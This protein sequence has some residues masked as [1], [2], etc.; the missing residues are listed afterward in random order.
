M[1]HLET[2][3]FRVTFW[4]VRGSIPCPGQKTLRYGGNTSCIEMLVGQ[5]RLIFDGGT[6]LR[7]LG[8]FL[9][10]TH[11]QQKIKGHLFF[12]HTHWDHIQ[13]FPFFAPAF[14]K[15]NQFQIYGVPNSEKCTIEHRLSD[16][17]LHPNFPVPLQIMQGN[18]A[19]YHLQVGEVLTLGAEIRVENRPLNHPGQAVGYRVSW[20][21]ITV[22][23]ITDTEHFG[24]RLD[25]NVIHLAHQADVLIIDATYTDEEYHDLEGGKKG[26]GH[27]TWQEAI[28]VAQAAQVKELI[29]FHHDPAHDDDQLEAILEQAQ[30]RFPRTRLAQEGLTLEL[31]P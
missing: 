9:M 17:M 23:F 2:E 1:T 26:W 31:L 19:F 18:L 14:T 11:P 28:K 27:S 12:T 30:S 29:L 8:D 24:D 20:R 15:G 21:G 5:E 13:G 7:V 10:A 16:Q 6:G 3:G 4:G 25:A 22:A